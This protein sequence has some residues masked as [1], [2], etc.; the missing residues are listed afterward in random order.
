MKRKRL[1][2]SSIKSAAYNPVSQLLEIEFVHGGIYQYKGV[3]AEVSELFFEA[4]SHGQF[5][6]HNIRNAYDYVKVG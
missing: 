4:E 5:Y 6:V 3:P 1:D 2:S